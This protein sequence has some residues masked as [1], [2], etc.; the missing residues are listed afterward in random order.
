MSITHRLDSPEVGRTT[1]RMTTTIGVWVSKLI[2]WRSRE[3]V[4]ALVFANL[5]KAVVGARH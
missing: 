4:A 3:I 2:F 1:L 5:I